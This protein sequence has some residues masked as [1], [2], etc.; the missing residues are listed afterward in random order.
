MSR[1]NSNNEVSLRREVEE[2]RE[3]ASRL[4]FMADVAPVFLSYVDRSQHYRFNNLAYEV[5]FQRPRINITGT[6]IRDA[7][8]VSGYS[9]IEKHVAAVLR[10]NDV[11]FDMS[12]QK[13]GQDH[14]LAVSYVPDQSA[15]GSV[16]GFYAAVMDR[17]VHRRVLPADSIDSFCRQHSFSKRESEVL[18][19]ASQGFANKKIADLMGCAHSSV[20]SYWKR[21]YRKMC[22]QTRS[23]VLALL[24]QFQAQ[25]LAVSCDPG[26]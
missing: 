20:I 24:I 19:L 22:C 11:S 7:L 9:Q 12:L 10:G 13:A 3:R 8:G 18:R 17:A 25:L 16:R 21:I 5:W 15:D 26:I 6:H 23:E 1:E 2:L 14:Q 4:H